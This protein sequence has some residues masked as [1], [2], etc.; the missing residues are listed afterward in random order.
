MAYGTELF[1]GF[2]GREHIDL[3]AKELGLEIEWDDEGGDFADLDKLEQLN[4]RLKLCWLSAITDLGLNVASAVDPEYP[5]I[6][7]PT[8]SRMMSP[9]RLS[10]YYDCHEMGDTEDDAILGISLITRY[11]PTFL[12]WRCDHGGSGDVITLNE[13]TM[14]CI[15]V[16]K[17]HII[18]V[19]PSFE[20]AV[21]HIKELHY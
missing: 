3:I 6:A 14:A 1:I 12:D 15:E 16:A 19:L 7:T 5:T 11:F 13:G 18:K 4:D 10:F 17:K 2:R 9:W 21:I 20:N 8:G